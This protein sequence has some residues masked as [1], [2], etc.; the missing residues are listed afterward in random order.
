MIR[1]FGFLACLLGLIRVASATEIEAEQVAFFENEVRPLLVEHCY[2]CH[3]H[4]SEIN[5]GLALDSMPGW[6]NGGDSGTTIVPGDPDA[7]LLMK[8]VRYAD[9]DY[10]MPPDG[11]LDDGSIETLRKWIA[12]GAPDPRTGILPADT[13]ESAGRTQ[14]SAEEL[15]S[16]QPIAKPKP[17]SVCDPS[18]ASEP[19]DAFV[20]ANLDEAKLPPAPPADA[21]VL[22]RRLYLDLIGL[23]PSPEE[24][25]AFVAAAEDDREA[26]VRLAVDTL[27]ASPAFGE[28]WARHW[29]DLTAYA[30]TLGVGRA[31]PAI[32]AYRY[33]DYVIDAFN[34]DKPLPEFIR[35]QIAGDIQ[36]PGAPGQQPTE[37]PTA[38]DIIATGFL[39][40]G[41]W[42]LVS[43]DK[44]QLRMDVVDRQVNR[45]GKAFLGMT[46]ECARCHAHKFDPVSQ[47]DYYAMAGILRSSITLD[48][49][50]NGVFSNVNYVELPETPNQLIE[51]AERIRQFERDFAEATSDR[52]EAAKQVRDQ[53][54]VVNRLKKVQE[55]SEESDSA[56]EELAAAEAILENAKKRQ[57]D[58]TK[59]RNLLSY[60]RPHRTK[61]LAIAMQDRPEPEPAAIN[62]RGNAHQ[63]GEP[64]PRGFLLP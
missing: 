57:A 49:R 19:I 12:M 8:A 9:P 52:D 45:I 61:S 14:V 36:V 6:R 38:E 29:L 15:W 41:P 13:P 31:I 53:Q 1:A 28:R 63:L 5:G 24:M 22:F 2:E 11:K 35:Q 55:Q 23:P 48:G 47:E 26:A 40:I 7:S 44:E 30:D 59:R 42:E 39:A 62:I 64:V 18:W 4:E 21:R 43:G 51:R 3:A 33:R 58:A 60:L 54:A 16:F 37:P 10:E 56:S 25:D 32:E 20:K 46:L 17:K 27:L 50:L 34:D